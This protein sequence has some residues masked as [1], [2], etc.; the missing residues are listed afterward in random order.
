MNKI[1]RILKAMM[2]TSLFIA[3]IL[4]IIFILLKLNYLSLIVFLILSIFCLFLH[5]YNEEE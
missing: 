5:F 2:K 3:V 4:T 1:T